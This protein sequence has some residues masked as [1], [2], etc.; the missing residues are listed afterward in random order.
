MKKQNKILTP[1]KRKICISE[2]MNEAALSVSEMEVA[3]RMNEA[4]SMVRMNEALTSSR[5]LGAY[6]LLSK[7]W[8]VT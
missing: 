5:E 1:E 7:D 8:R 6:W 3:A 2:T 4:L